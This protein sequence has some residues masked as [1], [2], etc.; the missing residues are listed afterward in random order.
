MYIAL[1]KEGRY[2][3][4]KVVDGHLIKIY[5]SEEK[6]VE[7]YHLLVKTWYGK[8]LTEELL[9]SFNINNLGYIKTD[10]GF[11][12]YD[13]SKQEY[14]EEKLPVYVDLFGSIKETKKTV[15]L[16]TPTKES[17]D[18]SKII[19]KKVEAHLTKLKHEEDIQIIHNSLEAGN[20]IA[21]INTKTNLFEVLSEENIKILF[22]SNQGYI[23][24]KVAK[25]PILDLYVP[26]SIIPMVIGKGGQMIKK[27][28]T[29]IGAKKINVKPIIK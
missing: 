24:G 14:T 25:M 7:I 26:E 4:G 1:Y 8:I 28:T 22:S 13:T 5:D 29:E 20:G 3:K 10:T 6:F 17:I 2:Y 9:K 12:L 21:Y 18:A 11:M 23:L 16:K 19:Y 27:I 15:V